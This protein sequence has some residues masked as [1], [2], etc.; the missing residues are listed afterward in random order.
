MAKQKKA[1]R[2]YADPDTTLI[3]AVVGLVVVGLMMNYSATF[4]WSYQL[5]GNS[6]QIALRQFGWVGVG[7]VAMVG[8]TFF[9]YDRWQQLAVPVLGAT[10]LSLMLSCLWEMRSSGRSALSSADPFTRASWPS[11]P[12]SST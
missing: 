6:L 2:P 12:W 4:D 3:V 8:F 9:P 5:Y 10:L 1:R 11:S 7:I